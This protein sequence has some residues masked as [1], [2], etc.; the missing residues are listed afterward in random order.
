[1]DNLSGTLLLASP[2]MNDPNFARAVI[3]MVEHNDEGALGLVLNKP[4]D[5]RVD[6][7]WDQISLLPG[8]VDQH[9]YNGGP[10][11]GPLMLLHNREPYAQVEICKGICFSTESDLVC[12]VVEG[13]DTDIGF[14]VGYA[15]WSA[16]Q[17]EEELDAGAWLIAQASPEV[18]FDPQ[19]G[20]ELWMRV[21][22]G[23]DRAIAMLAM[24]P[25]IVPRD[26]SMN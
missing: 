2:K 7:V 13:D 8:P 10:C 6:E 12:D 11:P 20:D 18:V 25:K 17:L 15:G 4:M 9:L 14:Y 5:T 1:M 16:G 21:I 19:P 3:L 22:S 23:I 26:P 24:N